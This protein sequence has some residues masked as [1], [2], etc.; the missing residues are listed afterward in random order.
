MK[1]FIVKKKMAIKAT[2]SAV[3]DA[4][5]NPRKTKKYFFNCEVFSDWEVGSP[6]VFSGHIFILKKIEMKGTIIQIEPEKLLKYTLQNGDDREEAST[7]STV[8]DELT[9]ENGV[10][11]LIITDDVGQGEGAAKRYAKSVKGWTSVLKG[12]R[13]LVEKESKE[14]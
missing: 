10:T 1:E 14:E 3:W 7:F 11:T 2:P 8:T 6:I 5:T 12:L 4:L 13:K 9:Y